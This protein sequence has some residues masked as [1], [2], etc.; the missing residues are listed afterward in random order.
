MKVLK[1]LLTFILWIIEYFIIFGIGAL[2]FGRPLMQVSMLLFYVALILF[3]IICI[4][5]WKLIF[6][7][8]KNE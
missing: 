5:T 7:K 8:K 3:I 1:F 2:P 6:K 4:I